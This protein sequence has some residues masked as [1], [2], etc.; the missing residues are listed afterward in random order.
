MVEEWRTTHVSE[1]YEVS[2]FGRVR[3]WAVRGSTTKVA[4]EPRLMKP[5]KHKDGHLAIWFQSEKVRIFIHTLVLTAFVGPKSEGFMCRHLDGDPANNV[6]NNLCW[7]TDTENKADARRHGTMPMGARHGSAKLTEKEAREI[8]SSTE[9]TIV[10]AAR[11]GVS[12]SLISA[13]RHGRIWR[14]LSAG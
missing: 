11:Y 12:D 14:S 7:G 8:K 9:M 3:S 2:N 1:K 13:I 4:R 5:Q 6:L 10:L